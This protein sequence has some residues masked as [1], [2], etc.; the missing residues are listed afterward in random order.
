[1]F[2]QIKTFE[3]LLAEF[4]EPDITLVDEA[5]GDHMGYTIYY[6]QSK[7]LMVWDSWANSLSSVRFGP[8]TDELLGRADAAQLGRSLS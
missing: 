4:G 8:P 1:M 6:N 7:K 5:Y 3:A 2:A